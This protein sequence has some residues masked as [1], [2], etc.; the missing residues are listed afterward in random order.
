MGEQ[1]DGKSE[2]NAKN[3]EL[4]C[5]LITGIQVKNRTVNYQGRGNN[6]MG[7]GNC[8][9]FLTILVEIVDSLHTVLI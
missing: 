4:R 2:Y 7:E 8:C 1:I 3:D 6:G 5:M 9:F